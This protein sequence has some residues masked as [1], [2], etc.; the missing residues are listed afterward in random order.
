MADKTDDDVS[1]SVK[2]HVPEWFRGAVKTYVLP[3]M[4]FFAGGGVTGGFMFHSV[5][6]DD[7][8]KATT[9]AVVEAVK[10]IQ[11]RLNTLEQR[12]TDTERAY[13]AYRE[14]LAAI[15]KARLPTRNR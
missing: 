3:V 13:I 11:E 1:G 5:S 15:E 9:E 8:K 10:P 7:V 12:Q 6:V 14:R 2:L 4:I